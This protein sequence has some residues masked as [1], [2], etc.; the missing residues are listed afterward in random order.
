MN[1]DRIVK[2]MGLVLLELANGVM[3]S[4]LRARTRNPLRKKR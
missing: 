2:L 1:G 3:Q 4:T